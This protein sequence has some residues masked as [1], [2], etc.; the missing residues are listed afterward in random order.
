MN[1]EHEK[2]ICYSPMVSNKEGIEMPDA[3]NISEKLAIP[4]YGNNFEESV[5]IEWLRSRGS[6]L[7]SDCD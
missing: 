5:I 3:R 4:N 2:D 7:E 6:E 1:P